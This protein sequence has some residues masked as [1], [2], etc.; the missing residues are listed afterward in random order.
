MALSIALREVVALM[1]LTDEMRQQ[2][3]ELVDEK[4]IIK[5]KVLED[6]V[7]AIELAKLQ[8]FWPRTKHIACQYH[9]F[10]S[11]TTQ[12]PNGEEPKIKVE[13][14]KTEYQQADIMMK[15]LGKQSFKK[16]RWLICGW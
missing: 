9:H 3:I 8:K 2:G 5:C 6:N 10:R 12:G 11:W 14:I 4:P 1:N 15:P 7:G 13:Y 16:L